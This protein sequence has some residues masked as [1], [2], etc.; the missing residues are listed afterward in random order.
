VMAVVDERAG[1]KFTTAVPA[2][3]TSSMLG[4]RAVYDLEG[5]GKLEVVERDLSTTILRKHD[6][7]EVCSDVVPF[8]D[9]GC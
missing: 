7:S 8:C 3:E 5:D 1:N 6:A 9:C 4:V 2:W